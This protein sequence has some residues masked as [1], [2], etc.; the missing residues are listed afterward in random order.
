MSVIE[1]AEKIVD[2]LPEDTFFI[3]LEY[4]GENERK[5]TISCRAK[6]EFAL[7]ELMS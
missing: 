7:S 1:W 2:S 4:L 3:Q 6:K 5:L